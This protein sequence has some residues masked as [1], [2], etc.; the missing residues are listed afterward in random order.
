MYDYP[1]GYEKHPEGAHYAKVRREEL[2]ARY[3][4]LEAQGNIRGVATGH[5]FK[6]KAPHIQGSPEYLVVAVDH[7]ARND[8]YRTGTTQAGPPYIC[9]L[10]AIPI[11]QQFRAARLTPRP[12]VK[13]P[14]TAI[15]V[16]PGGEE[17]YVDSGPGYGRVKVRFPWDRGETADENASCWIRVA[18]VWAGAKWGAMYIPRMGHEVI[19]DFLEGDPDRPI[20]TGRVY[21]NDNMPPYALP[22]NKTVSTMQ[23]RSS[24]GGGPANFNEIKFEDKKGSEL[25]YIQAEKDRDMLVKNNNS[26]NIGNDE[27]VHVGHD[28]KKNIDNNETTVVGVNRTETVG[29]NEKI[30]IGSNRTEDVGKHE[31][32]NIGLTRTKTVGVNDMLNVGVAQEISIGGLQMLTVGAARVTSIGL[33]DSLTVGKKLT[34]DA[35]DQI[36][37]KT[38]EASITMKKD[39][40]IAIKGKDISLKASGKISVKADSDVTIKGS[41]IAQN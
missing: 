38:G 37:I 18:Q 34:I 7:L 36:I 4:T 12:I 6:L 10:E 41:K 39:G 24:K 30:T 16:G 25:L 32:V 40:T 17:I 21:N 29:S 8:D 3:E 11:Q 27:S 35:G 14:Q 33:N 13:G 26:E 5:R 2:Q 15:V 19:V 28:R 20:I 23:S 31:V 1:G 9:T 22:Q